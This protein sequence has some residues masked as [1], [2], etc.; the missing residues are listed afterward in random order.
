MYEPVEIV[1]DHIRNVR[2]VPVRNQTSQIG[3]STDMTEQIEE[4]FIREGRLRV[5]DSRDA[6][7]ALYTT[8]V[9]YNKIPVSYDENFIVEEYQLSMVVELVFV[10]NIKELRLWEEKRKDHRGGIEASVIYNVS[11]DRG[12]TETEEEA[13]QRLIKEIARRIL[14][15][16]IYGWE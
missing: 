6:D 3:I 8:V 9:R 11:H 7:S 1:P 15:R 5:T 14:Q 2:V 16:T 4:E 13:R 10:D 12:Y